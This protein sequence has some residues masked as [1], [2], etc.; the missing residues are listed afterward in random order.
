MSA[1]YAH[2]AYG[3]AWFAHPP[4]VPSS[5]QLRTA[6]LRTAEFE[7]PGMS[8]TARKVIGL[9]AA[10]VLAALAGGTLVFLAATKDPVDASQVISAVVAV[11]ATT[12]AGL[13]ALWAFGQ[14]QSAPPGAPLHPSAVRLPGSVHSGRDSLVNIGS[15]GIHIRRGDSSVVVVLVITLIVLALAAYLVLRPKPLVEVEGAAVC[16]DGMPVSGVY[17]HTES[18]NREGFVDLRPTGLN[19]VTFAKRITEH[20][21]WQVSV[22]CGSR[23]DSSGSWLTTND[24]DY[25]W[26]ERRVFDCRAPSGAE[27]GTCVER[28]E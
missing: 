22:G 23:P 24:S 25:R 17:V 15:G 3:H 20:D 7:V 6:T 19:E 27:K 1:P 13:S 21:P 11:V 18:G 16:S 9:I 14:A 12:G 2:L 26:A 5:G 28:P 10:F 8:T 4:P